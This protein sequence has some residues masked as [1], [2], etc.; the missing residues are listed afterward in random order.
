MKIFLIVDGLEVKPTPSNVVPTEAIQELER[1]M[2]EMEDTYNCSICLEKVR[3][4]VFLCGHSACNQCAQPL[5]VCHMCRKP[6][7][8]KINVY[9]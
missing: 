3:T 6:I 9:T 8:K 1:K 4:V 2:R 7:T 5:K